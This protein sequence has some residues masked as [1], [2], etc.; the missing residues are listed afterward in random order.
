VTD[1]IFYVLVLLAILGTACMAGMFYAFSVFVMKGLDRLPSPTG[2][3]AMQSINAAVGNPV[4]GLGFVGTALLCL[5]LAVSSLFM[6]GEDG[7]PLVLAASVLY[8]AGGLV[9]TVRYHIPRNNRLMKVDPTGVGSEDWW[10]QYVAEWTTWNHVR[11]IASLAATGLFAVA[12][13]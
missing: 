4:F 13:T 2:I 9:L 7:A 6:L 8:L 11:T 10:R 1:G 12:L 3:A 5:V